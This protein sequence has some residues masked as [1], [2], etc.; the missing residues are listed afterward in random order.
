R[1]AVRG[2]RDQLRHSGASGR[3]RHVQYRK[4]S[5]EHRLEQLRHHARELVGAATRA[6]RHDDLDRTRRVFLLRRGRRS[7]E[8]QCEEKMFHWRSWYLSRRRCGFFSA[9]RRNGSPSSRVHISSTMVVL[10]SFCALQASR[11]AGPTSESL[12]TLLPSACIAFA[13]PAKL[14]FSRFTP[15]KRFE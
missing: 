5:A 1:V 3:A 10:P 13:M 2:S 9:S 7:G 6:P 14:G 12:S 11:S 8:K 15:R 4:R